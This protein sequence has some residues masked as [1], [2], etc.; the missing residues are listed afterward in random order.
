VRRRQNS[1]FQIP[2]SKRVTAADWLNAALEFGIWN[3]ELAPRRRR[4]AR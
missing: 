1:K 2:N 4:G 3:L